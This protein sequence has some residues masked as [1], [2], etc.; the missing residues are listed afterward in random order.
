MKI[1]SVSRTGNECDII[2]PFVRHHAKVV[3]FLIV[4]DDNSTDGTADILEGLK[5]EGLPL[6]TIQAKDVVW[7]DALFTTEMMRL[8]FDEH[9]ADWVA[10]LDIDEFIEAPGRDAL[11][12]VLPDNW[13]D[14]LALPWANFGWDANLSP[15]IIN[16][17]VRLRTRMPLSLVVPK[18]L[19][20]RRAVDGALELSII[21]G[22]H[23]LRVDGEKLNFQT[24]DGLSLCHFPIRSIDQFVSK[25]VIM[26]LRYV[27]RFGSMGDYAFQYRKAIDLVL[28]GDTVALVKEMERTSRIYGLP[29]GYELYVRPVVRPMRYLG[30]PLKFKGSARKSLSNVVR[31]A[32]ALA[33]R[34]AEL[35]GGAARPA[36]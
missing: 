16:P 22:N 6:E 34:V 23:G 36:P 17:V 18:P 31:H 10:V 14:V 3:D 5:A 24:I 7:D 9:N 1:V 28:Q 2:E 11:R 12:D 25:S 32:E 15:K 21:H 4:I 27:A 8:A 35:E 19:I 26:Y 29:E 30:G 20:P 13:S 33:Q